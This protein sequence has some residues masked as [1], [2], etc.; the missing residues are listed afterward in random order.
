MEDNIPGGQMMVNV[1]YE[2]I[3]SNNVV[4]EGNL[5][6]EPNQ[7]NRMYSWTAQ[8]H[9]NACIGSIVVSHA[10]YTLQTTTVSRKFSALTCMY[11]IIIIKILSHKIV[12]AIYT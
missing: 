1:N 10:V 4:T 9:S 6:V 3:V 5:A 11:I 2:W 7:P 12:Q 8:I